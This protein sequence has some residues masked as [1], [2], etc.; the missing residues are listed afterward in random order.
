MCTYKNCLVTP[1]PL[2]DDFEHLCRI[3]DLFR[4]EVRARAHPSFINRRMRALV[5][6][7]ADHRARREAIL[8]VDGVTDPLSMRVR[9]AFV[10]QTIAEAHQQFQAEEFRLTPDRLAQNVQEAVNSL[11]MFG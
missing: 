10:S 3:A 1:D 5:G 8:L 11:R 2:H 6:L 4:R 7:W 9:H